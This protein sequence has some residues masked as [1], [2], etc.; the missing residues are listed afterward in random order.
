M[1]RV[2]FNRTDA[3]KIQSFSMSGHAEF[4]DSGKDL[5]CAGASAVAFGAV[6]SLFENAQ[7]EPIIDL[8]QDGGYLAVEL[9]LL[10]DEMTM[11]KVE[12]I[13]ETLRT[14]L[15]TIEKD[16]GQYIKISYN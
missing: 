2:E 3:G 6:N 13:L 9:P 10:E 12:I 8:G 1:I 4:D 16:Y 7:I 11:L 14:S 5:V 15:E